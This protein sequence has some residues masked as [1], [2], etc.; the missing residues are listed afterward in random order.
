MA[1]DI[2]EA[3]E[4]FIEGIEDAVAIH[5]R[6]CGCSYCGLIYAKLT[7]FKEECEWLLT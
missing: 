2:E 4:D 6:T 7:E 3:V 5:L 1:N